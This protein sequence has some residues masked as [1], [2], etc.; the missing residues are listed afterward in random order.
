MSISQYQKM[1]F[2][3]SGGNFYLCFSLHRIRKFL[4][5]TEVAVHWVL[6]CQVPGTFYNNISLN[7]PQRD[8]DRKSFLCLI[9]R[10]NLFISLPPFLHLWD[11]LWVNAMPNGTLTK[12]IFKSVFFQN[13]NL[14]DIYEMSR[15]CFL[16][17]R[18]ETQEWAKISP[19][20][21][22]KG[23]LQPH[24]T[25]WRETPHAE[26]SGSYRGT[27]YKNLGTL[28]DT[29]FNDSLITLHTVL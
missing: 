9:D 29:I 16:Q 20:P 14:I 6:P 1:L 27:K 5:L 12:E 7:N 3:V 23:G 28:L 24:K 17:C 2:S 19:K 25:N 11:L 26:C 15:S 8:H 10:S 4:Y 22:T 13:L 21:C 18:H